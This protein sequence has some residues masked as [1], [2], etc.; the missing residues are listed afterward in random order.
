MKEW[1]ISCKP[2]PPGFSE[3]EID[4]AYM[5]KA[6][7]NGAARRF[8]MNIRTVEQQRRELPVLICEVEQVA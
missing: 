6:S 8:G 1:R 5:T 7:I 3:L 4:T 2:D